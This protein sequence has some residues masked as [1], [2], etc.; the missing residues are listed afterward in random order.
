MSPHP[1]NKMLTGPGEARAE[2][3][4]QT[5]PLAFSGRRG[6]ISPLT[7]KGSNAPDLAPPASPG[8]PSSRTLRSCFWEPHAESGRPASVRSCLHPLDAHGCAGAPFLSPARAAGPGGSGRS[9]RSLFLGVDA[10]L[11][12]EPRRGSETPLCSILALSPLASAQSSS[13]PGTSGSGEAHRSCSLQDSGELGAGR[14][15]PQACLTRANQLVP[16][17]RGSAPRGRA[18]V[19]TDAA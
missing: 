14:L 3:A 12:C 16:L 9:H 15:S 2:P 18:S 11:S 13:G 10:R 8:P 7:R 5:H 6:G 1:A 4:L 19:P 17:G